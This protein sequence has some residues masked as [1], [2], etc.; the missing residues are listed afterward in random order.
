VWRREEATATEV[1]KAEAEGV[2]KVTKV[3]SGNLGQ[4]L[5]ARNLRADGISNPP[6]PIFAGTRRIS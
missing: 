6:A 3:T 5:R 4:P 2:H 1:S